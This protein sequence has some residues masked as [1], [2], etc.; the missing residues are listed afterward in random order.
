MYILAAFCVLF[1]N[2]PSVTTFVDEELSVTLDQVKTW[3]AKFGNEINVG[4]SR[5]TCYDVINN[6]SSVILLPADL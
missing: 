6:V 2:L 3:A 1:I 5:A 4:S